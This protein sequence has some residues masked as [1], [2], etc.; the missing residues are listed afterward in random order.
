MT[1]AHQLNLLNVAK[2]IDTAAQPAA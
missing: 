1:P 2:A